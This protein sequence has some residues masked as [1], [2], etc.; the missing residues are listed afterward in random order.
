MPCVVTQAEH[1]Y[2]EREANKGRYGQMMTNVEVTT[3]ILCEATKLLAKNKLIEQGSQLL[4]K[5]FAEHQRMDREA[6][7]KAK[8]EADA[9][10][11]KKAALKKL[12]ADEKKALGL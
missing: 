7:A 5:W 12:S 1:E 10:R 4:Q 6:E 11:L 2:Y 8:N 3:A 9:V